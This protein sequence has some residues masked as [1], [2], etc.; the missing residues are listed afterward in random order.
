MNMY[1]R[2]TLMLL[3]LTF[4]SAASTFACDAHSSD[5]FYAPLEVGRGVLVFSPIP[6]LE[7][8]GKPNPEMGIGIDF[9][10]CATGAKKFVARLPYVTEPGEVKDAF[11]V[12]AAFGHEEVLIIHSVPIRA[13]TGVSYGSD[14]FSVIALRREGDD[15]I[16]NK[17]LTYYFGSGADVVVRGDDGDTPVYTFPYKLRDSVLDKLRSEKYQRW[18]KGTLPEIEVVRQAVIYSSMTVADPQNVYLIKGDK[19]IQES[20]SAGW[21]YILYETAKGKEIRGWVLCEDVGGC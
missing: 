6:V 19:V 21:I 15:F 12:S 10:D 1:L 16:L 4:G 17:E 9:L 2:L 8:E 7:D 13:F 14:Y 20:V 3:C 18:V 11:V 5:F